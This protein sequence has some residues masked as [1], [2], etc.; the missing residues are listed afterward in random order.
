MTGEKLF[1]RNVRT[2]KM[3]A[4]SEEDF[5]S[6]VIDLAHT[7]GW[8]VAHFRAARTKTGWRTAVS[9]DGE[10]FPDLLLTRG[11]VTIFAETKSETGRLSPQQR[12]W[13]QTLAENPR[14]RCFV[15]RPADRPQIEEILRGGK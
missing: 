2:S 8:L 14:N 3:P 4:E 7:M 13:L 9:A 11:A 12:V 6:W 5:Q 1:S 15:W 10:G